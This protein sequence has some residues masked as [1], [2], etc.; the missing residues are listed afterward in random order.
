M[1]YE[2]DHFILRTASVFPR[3]KE[4]LIFAINNYDLILSVM[5][6]RSSGES[7]DSEDFRQ[8]FDSKTS[9]YIEETLNPHFGDL[10]KFITECER[11]IE[12]GED[13]K[14]RSYEQKSGSIIISFNGKW[15]SALDEL[16][17]EV[18]GSFPNFKNGTNILQ[19]ALT[20]F[21]Q[22]YHRFHKIMAMPEFSQSAQQYPL[23]NVHQL[24][25]EVKKY[26]P[27]F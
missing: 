21:V 27:N 7:R 16:N 20:Q 13:S 15:K 3:R 12:K 10:I 11:F 19:Q 2:I 4:Q 8:K 24:I 5:G 1:H 23:I 22:Y 9:D 14:L 17:K 25:V 26:K 6:E 18:L